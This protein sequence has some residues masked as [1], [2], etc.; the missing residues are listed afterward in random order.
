MNFSILQ[1]SARSFLL[2]CLFACSLSPFTQKLSKFISFKTDDFAASVIGRYTQE[3][4]GAQNAKFLN[5][6]IPWDC[7]SYERSTID[8]AI[9]ALHGAVE[10]PRLLFH[11]TVRMRHKWGFATDARAND[12]EAVIGDTSVVIKGRTSDKHLIWTREVWMKMAMGNLDYPN[13]NYVQV[14]MIPFEVGRGISLGAAYT[15]RGFLGFSPG[16]SIDQFAPAVRL[17]LNP[18]AGRLVVDFYTAILENHMIGFKSNNAKIRQGDLSTKSLIRGLPGQSYISAVRSMVTIMDG[19]KDKLSVE[20][21]IVLQNGPDQDLEFTT[22]VQSHVTTYGCAIEGASGKLNWGFEGAMNQGEHSIKPW[23]RNLITIVNNPDTGALTQQ[24]TKIYV[25][26]PSTTCKPTL[27]YVEGAA[28]AAVKNTPKDPSLNGVEVAPGI[29][30]AFDRFR[31]QQQLLLSGYFLMA[32]ASYEC[33]DKVLVAT[34]GAGYASGYI[35]PQYNT[36]LLSSERLMNQHFTGFIPLQSVYSGKRLTQLFIFNKGVP[37][38]NTRNP[39]ANLIN[40]NITPFVQSDSI[41]EVTNI[42]FFGGCVDWTPKM[43]KDNKLKISPNVIG[44][45]SPESSSYVAQCGVNS[46][47]SGEV[48]R[49]PVL[50]T[51]S[52]FLGIE[53]TTKF[54]ADIYKQ[55]N[56]YSY[57]GVFFPGQHYTDMCGTLIDG[58]PTGNSTAFICD[59][60]MT[61]NF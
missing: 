26:D 31:P 54:S 51:A 22:D 55:F 32:D 8:F 28:L 37:R 1:L 60:G 47:C 19:I 56:V 21:Y 46:P 3:Y 15:V 50:V 11:Q 42:A 5:S 43:W 33:V 9:D 34:L 52:D 49:P 40:Q 38:F 35:D 13:D 4:F 53:F 29:W 39:S 30:N 45:W 59:I 44:Y 2:S 41:D 12:S 10:Q 7:S 17:S 6:A 18:I 25:C 36:N 24:Y 16:D 14:G 61:Y 58:Q 57:V 20:P 27:A 48:V 23:D